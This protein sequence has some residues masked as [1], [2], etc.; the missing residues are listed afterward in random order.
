MSGRCRVVRACVA[1]ALVLS[2][3]CAHR[4]HRDEHTAAS[5]DAAAAAIPPGA[6]ATRSAEAAASVS[7]AFFTKH[8]ELGA[9]WEVPM[10]ADAGKDVSGIADR[11]NAADA[12]PM[13]PGMSQVVLQDSC[14]EAFADRLVLASCATADFGAWRYYS[15][16]ALLGDADMRD[17]LKTLRGR[18]TELPHDSEEYRRAKA[19]H[20]A[21][22]AAE[23]A[24]Q[25]RRRFM[26][27]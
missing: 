23:Q 3:A 1:A 26:S 13:I 5:G 14:D 6:R 2:A 10:P 8:N 22:R 15:F 19:R 27:P 18:W 17:C 20:D 16:D 7:I 21:E 12:A 24:D 4:E 11:A 25:I 9:C